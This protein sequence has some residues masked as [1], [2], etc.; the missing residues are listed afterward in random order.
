MHREPRPGECVVITGGTDQDHP[1]PPGTLLIVDEVDSSDSTLRGIPRGQKAILDHWISWSNVDP[2][3]FGWR[4]ARRHLPAEVIALLSACDGVEFLQLNR[5]VKEAIVDSL[6]DWKQ[7]VLAA[8]AKGN[9]EPVCSSNDDDDF[10]VVS[11]D[12]DD[13]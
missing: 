9:E 3:A 2:V 7:R 12:D 6:P 4:Y 10:E 13:D 5:Q 1:L 8:I 11:D